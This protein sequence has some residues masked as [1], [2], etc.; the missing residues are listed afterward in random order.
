[1]HFLLLFL[2]KSIEEKLFLQLRK[3]LS[4]KPP[5]VVFF[6]KNQPSTN[7]YSTTSLPLTEADSLESK[8]TTR[9]EKYHV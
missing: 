1:M 2:S 6:A 7:F 4:Q 9:K 8:H 3:F 5:V